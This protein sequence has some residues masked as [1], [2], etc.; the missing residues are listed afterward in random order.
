M[1]EEDS[2]G[3]AIAAEVAALGR[4]E[5]GA[6]TAPPGWSAFSARLERP[7]L[8]SRLPLVLVIALRPLGELARPA[9]AGTLVATC[10][11]V[12]LGT[13]LALAF[14]RGPTAVALAATSYAGSNL[15]DGDDPGL[16]T[17]LG[18]GDSEAL[19]ADETLPESSGTGAR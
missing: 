16:D 8:A 14:D 2:G 6:A 1:H 3:T 18:D 17:Y 13:W 5:R 9:M 11:G 4:A 7:P 10:A 19:P 15:L 12:A